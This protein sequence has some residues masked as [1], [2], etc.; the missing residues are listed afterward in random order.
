MIHFHSIARQTNVKKVVK[1]QDSLSEMYGIIKPEYSQN[2]QTNHELLNYLGQFDKLIIAGEAE[3]HCVYESVRQIAEHF[4]NDLKWKK[5]IFVLT[6][7]MSC[8][9]GF[10]EEN[11]KAWKALSDKFNIQLVESTQLKL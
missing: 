3:S 7:G 4:S 8:I 9:P 11:K 5:N 1:G 6:D 10:E 2:D